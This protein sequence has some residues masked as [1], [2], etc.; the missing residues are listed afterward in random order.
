MAPAL[1]PPA[2]SHPVDFGHQRLPEVLQ[3]EGLERPGLRDHDELDAAVRGF[4]AGP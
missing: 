4:E 3:I 1:S 2:R